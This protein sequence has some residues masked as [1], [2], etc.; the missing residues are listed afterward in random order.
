MSKLKN[1]SFRQNKGTQTDASAMPAKV[2]SRSYHSQ[3]CSKQ[4]VG[5]VGPVESKANNQ[6]IDLNELVVAAASRVQLASELDQSQN[7]TKT[8]HYDWRSQADNKMTECLYMCLFLIALGLLIAIV[9]PFLYFLGFYLFGPIYA[10]MHE[11][12]NSDCHKRYRVAVILWTVIASLCPLFLFLGIAKSVCNCCKQ[13]SNE[14]IFIT[15]AKIFVLLIAIF[16]VVFIIVFRHSLIVVGNSEICSS[17]DYLVYFLIYNCAI[18]FH[19]ALKFFVPIFYWVGMLLLMA[20]Q[21]LFRGCYW[22]FCVLP[23][24]PKNYRTL[25][26]EYD[27]PALRINV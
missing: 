22:C 14:D 10:M 25:D 7:Y 9:L 17:R 6:S 15:S 4:M 24:F 13:W 18:V 21:A 19:V 26:E 23:T 1:F 16:T 20:L 27:S 8:A 5:M 2:L 12:P 11:D 3:A